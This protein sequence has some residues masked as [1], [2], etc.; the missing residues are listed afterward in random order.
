LPVVPMVVPN[1]AVARTAAGRSPSTLACCSTAPNG[2]AKTWLVP[3]ADLPAALRSAASHVE[4]TYRTSMCQFSYVG[5]LRED[6][7]MVALGP[8]P[9]EDA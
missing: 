1:G 4:A 6:G 2:P 5:A 8:K 9:R 3:A 7:P